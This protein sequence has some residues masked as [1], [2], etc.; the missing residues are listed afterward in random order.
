MNL[1]AK[2]CE[3][4]A[5]GRPLGLAHGWK[6]T[7]SVAAGEVVRWADVVVDAS[8]RAVQMR[9]EME[10]MFAAPPDLVVT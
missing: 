1:Y 7:R 5:Q 10:Q 4:A 6:L 3:H 9:R 8:N 2:L